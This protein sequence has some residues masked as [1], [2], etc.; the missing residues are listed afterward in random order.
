MTI[1]QV[2][3]TIIAIVLFAIISPILGCLLSGLDRIISARMQ[4][5]VGPPLLQPYYDIRKLLL[6]EK[7]SVNG[8]DSRYLSMA[9]LFTACAG[10]VFFSGGNLLM[11]I[12]LIAMANLLIIMAAYSSRSPYAEVGAHRELLQVLSYEPMLVLMAVAVSMKTQSFDVAS[13]LYLD[14]PLILFLIPIFIGFC[15]VLTIKLR[16]S[17]FDLASSHHAHQELVKGTTTEMSGPNLAKVEIIHMSETILFLGWVAMF[18]INSSPISIV[19][20]VVV[21]LLIWFFE[22]LIDN[23]FARI[24]WQIMIASSWIVTAICSIATFIILLFV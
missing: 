14:Q 17:P 20:A 9:L 10:G 13:V 7:K 23:N 12:F 2:A 4:G 15:Y 19:I 11:S 5:R 3:I 8:I 24:K 18:F 1:E 22:I 21:A 6:K 16:K